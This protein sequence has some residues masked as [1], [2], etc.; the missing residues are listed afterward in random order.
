[1]EGESKEVKKGTETKLSCLITGIT[2]TVT[3]TW[4]KSGQSVSGNSNIVVVPGTVETNKQTS[5]LT[6]KS[7]EVQGDASY[8]CRVRSGEFS[9]SPAKDTVVLLNVYG[10]KLWI[11]NLELFY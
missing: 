3:V 1:M 4:T 9:H 10:K 5:T 8:T 6:I 7:A 11:C 2:Q